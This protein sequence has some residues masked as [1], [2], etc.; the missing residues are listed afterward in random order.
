MF[1]KDVQNIGD[2]VMHEMTTY[3]DF[4]DSEIE[5]VEATAKGVISKIISATPYT[6]PYVLSITD[7]KEN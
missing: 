7:Q 2:R 1:I 3:S 4:S 6:I 5:T